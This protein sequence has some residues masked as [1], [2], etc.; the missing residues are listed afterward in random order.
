MGLPGYRGWATHVTPFIS[1]SVTG[2]PAPKKYPSAPPTFLTSD[3]LMAVLAG[4]P[5]KL[6]S[7]RNSRPY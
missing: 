6:P 7:L 3:S 1:R 2:P 5:P 4:P